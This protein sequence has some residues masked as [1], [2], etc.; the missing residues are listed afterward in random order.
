MTETPAGNRN[1]NMDLLDPLGLWLDLISG[2]APDNPYGGSATAATAF[3]IRKSGVAS[4]I[5]GQ[6]M[7]ICDRRPT[8]EIS[9][10]AAGSK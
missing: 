3:Q 1:C 9:F 6:R 7:S 10:C 8:P 4:R 5:L 2:A